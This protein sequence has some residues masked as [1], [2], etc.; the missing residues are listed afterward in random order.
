M[1]AKQPE[2]SLPGKGQQ[3]MLCDGDVLRHQGVGV[4]SWVCLAC[5]VCVCVCVVCHLLLTNLALT[6][7]PK[8]T[9]T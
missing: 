7:R 4:Y 5:H 9:K 1:K 3:N 8:E 2:Q 6:N